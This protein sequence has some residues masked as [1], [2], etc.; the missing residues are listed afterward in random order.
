VEGRY[1]PYRQTTRELHAQEAGRA[2]QAVLARG[3]LRCIP[4]MREENLGVRVVTRQFNVGQRNHGDARVAHLEAD[5]LRKFSLDLIRNLAVSGVGHVKLGE[6]ARHL[7]RF[8]GFELIAFFDVVEVLDR[9]TAL[10]A[11]FDF[12]HVILK[13]LQRIEFAGE[14][15]HPIAQQA[16]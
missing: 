13:A 12:L 6:G 11:C 4:K 5:Q 8:E 10:K 7:C 3:D 2:I 15:D 1:N 16:N 14:D 9:Q